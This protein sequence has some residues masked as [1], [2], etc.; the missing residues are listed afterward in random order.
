MREVCMYPLKCTDTVHPT[1]GTCGTIY[2][3]PS[4]LPSIRDSK[5][6]QLLYIQVERRE[7]LTKGYRPL[8]SGEDTKNGKGPKMDIWI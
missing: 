5:T 4:I 7:S 6:R 2:V 3:T 1:T 8:L